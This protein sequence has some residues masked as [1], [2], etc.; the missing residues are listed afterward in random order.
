MYPPD[1]DLDHLHEIGQQ[2]QHSQRTVAFLC[3][4][5]GFVNYFVHTWGNNDVVLSTADAVTHLVGQVH[6][7]SVL[8]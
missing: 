2:A 7:G 4:L 5:M 6:F 3:S 8:S 1:L